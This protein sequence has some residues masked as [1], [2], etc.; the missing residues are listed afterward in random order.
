MVAELR[1][2]SLK[3]GSTMG[4]PRAM[5]ERV[6]PV[7]AAPSLDPDC[8]VCADDV[9]RAWPD[10]ASMQRCFQELKVDDPSAV[11]KV[12]DTVPG[13]GEDVAVDCV[14]I[15]VALSCNYVGQTVEELAAMSAGD[16]AALRA[17]VADWLRMD[18]A[19]HVIDTVADLPAL[20]D[21]LD[22]T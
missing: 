9:P 3:I 1:A 19:G 12:N 14:T 5:M 22:H 17:G 4:Y 16:V 6:L 11:I 2:R 8:L 7:A 13:I 18:S 20:L 15:R 10:P 21:R